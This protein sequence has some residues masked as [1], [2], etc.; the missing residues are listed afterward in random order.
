MASPDKNH[1]KLEKMS[2]FE[3]LNSHPDDVKQAMKI[4]E[5]KEDSDLNVSSIYGPAARVLHQLGLNRKDPEVRQ[6]FVQFA[7]QE[8][9]IKPE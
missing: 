6:E 2:T 4:A 5:V 1:A 3:R 9:L 8:G 7:Q